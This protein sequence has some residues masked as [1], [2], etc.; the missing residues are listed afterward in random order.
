[1]EATQTTARTKELKARKYR[2]LLPRLCEVQR[3]ELRASIEEIGLQQPIDVDG[4]GDVLDG[5]ERL[6]ICI[7]LGME[8]VP[9]RVL[10]DLIDEY[11]RRRY[12]VAVNSVRRVLTA[13]QRRQMAERLLV[14]DP[15]E[16]DRVIADLAGCSHSSV[17]TWRAQMES[18]GRIP[19]VLH[20]RGGDG[21]MRP[22]KANP[23]RSVGD[24]KAD[25]SDAEE[26]WA[27]PQPDHVLTRAMVTLARNTSGTPDS[28][29]A[30]VPNAV[31]EVEL[32]RSV[33]DNPTD[34]G[35]EILPRPN[36]PLEEIDRI[37]AG[38]L[39]AGWLDAHVIQI[40][41]GGTPIAH[42]KV[43]RAARSD[44]SLIKPRGNVKSEGWMGVLN[45][46]SHG[47]CRRAVGL[48]GT[49][50]PCYSDD[51]GR[52][53]CLVDALP[54]SKRPE[55]AEGQVILNGLSNDLLRITLPLDGAPSLDDRVPPDR[56]DERMTWRVDCESSTGD[57]SIAL[58]VLQRW[59]ESNPTHRFVTV[60]SNHFRPSDAML[61]W[62]AALN[63]VVVGHSVSG[64]FSPEEL[65]S[66]FA[67]I[68]RFLDW[69][70]PTVIRVVT[71]P[72]WDNGL[73]LT[74]ALELVGPDQIIEEPHRLGPGRQQPP[75]LHINPA[76]PCSSGRVDG[77]KRALVFVPGEDDQPGEY[78]VPLADGGY[79]KPKGSVHSRCRGCQVRCGLTA[80][81]LMERADV[82]DTPDVV[83]LRPI[84][85]TPFPA[86]D[87]LCWEV[88][89]GD[90][91]QLIRLLDRQVH[92]V[93]TSPPYFNLK[94]YGGDPL[95]IGRESDPIAYVETLCDIFDAIPL[96]PLGSLW[97]NLRDKREDRVL[98]CIPERFVV[99]MRDRGWNLL[100]RI[101]WAKS[102]LNTDGT[103]LGNLMVEPAPGRLNGNGWEHVFRF[104][105]TSQPWADDCAISIPR[106]NGD[107]AR[108][109]PP[110]QM[111]LP[112]V[113]DGR[114]PPD[115]WLFGPDRS[116][117]A[118]VAPWP[119][120]VC[121]IPIAL[122]CPLWVQPDGSL[123][124]RRVV[125]SQYE[126]GHGRR[127]MGKY[128]HPD[129]LVDGGP[130]RHDTGRTYIARKPQSLGWTEIADGAQPG[131]VCDPFMGVGTTGLVA[132]RLGRRF[133]GIDLYDQFCEGARRDLESTLRQLE[134]E[135]WAAEPL[136]A[137]A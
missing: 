49:D 69:G 99:A 72:D 96:H 12:A 84:V 91:R 88:L 66:R 45:S 30:A 74:R 17:A 29:V 27:A 113:L 61:A 70:V 109:L 37:P 120:V 82:E 92:C 31:R 47:C 80:H 50:R 64:A 18:E 101:V 44:D 125:A 52:T 71:D 98:D 123:P 132:L 76:G 5:H 40:R 65:D 86:A 16:S 118:H 117:G 105:R 127:E 57:L 119:E 11:S 35:A 94:A 68:E 135:E 42:V 26:T 97:I 41:K 110:E 89:C 126:D 122:S 4:D 112:T 62:L 24:G 54:C 32:A 106:V 38:Q 1:M 103:T 134:R 6:A 51:Q 28:N 90:A 3:A 124:E 108:Y 137:N 83:D 10:A 87:Q 56:V 59:C 129:L 43:R 95:E 19:H 85:P 22:A 78:L 102:A 67:A 36:L 14:E 81:G 15:V 9:I 60:C 20:H 136:V 33:W 104:S 13:L 73:V 21:K 111:H 23:G 100:D 53:G 77:K 7:E 114:I 25:A 93:V 128:L 79:D 133:V 130:Q 58:G 115:V 107:G 63:N 2:L 34:D 46:C 75:V 48:P 131:L 116:G 55:F 8:Q 121:E 39:E